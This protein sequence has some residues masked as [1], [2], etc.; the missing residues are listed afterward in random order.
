MEKALIAL[1]GV[2]IGILLNE[3]FRKRSRIETYSQRIFDKRLEVY[4]GLMAIIQESYN[5]ASE[6][7]ENSELSK[8]N[9]HTIISGAIVPLAKYTD[10]N[11]LYLDSYIGAQATALLM[12]VEDIQDIEDKL[13]KESAI[14][15]FRADYKATK[16]II[17]ADSGVAEVNKHF[18]AISK[19]NPSTPIIEYI[20][21]HEKNKA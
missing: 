10:D 19:S 20:K 18:E 4:E 5:V 13:E 6:V 15:R 14:S 8:E 2:L 7:I 17:I 3:H 9:R 21:K 16:E 1:A 11:A 12:G